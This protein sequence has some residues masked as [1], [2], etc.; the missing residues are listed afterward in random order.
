MSHTLLIAGTNTSVGKTV[1]TSCLAAYWQSYRLPQT[2]TLIKLIQTGY[3]DVELYRQL[4]GQTSQINILN[5][6]HFDAPFAPPIAAAKQGREVPLELVWQDVVRSQQQS[7]FVLIEALGGLGSPVT[8]E[9]TVADLASY[10]RLP[11]VLVVPVRLGGIAEAVVNIA[12]ARQN[13]INLRGIILSC[14]NPDSE[15]NLEDLTPI[16]LVESLTNTPV[17]GVLPYLAETN[18]ISKLVHIASNLEIEK[19]IY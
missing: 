9:L 7:D 3:G 14:V 10:W 16:Y 13:K 18:N 6:L 8:N 15:T 4:F 1:F 17:L 2:L 19:L 5:P 12:F 11:T